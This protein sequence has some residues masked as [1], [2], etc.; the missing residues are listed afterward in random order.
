MTA[1]GGCE[2]KSKGLEDDIRAVQMKELEILK[3]VAKVCEDNGLRYFANGGTLLGAVRHKGFIPWDDDV[4]IGMP[5]KDYERFRQ[6]A[7]QA[8]PEHLRVMDYDREQQV[9]RLYLKVHDI[10]TTDIEIECL[11]RPGQHSGVF[12]DIF[13]YD[14]CSASPEEQ[15]K[16]KKRLKRLEYINIQLRIGEPIAPLRWAKRIILW[17]ARLAL[18]W[19]WASRQTEKLVSKQDMDASEYTHTNMA[20]L[21]PSQWLRQTVR[22]PFEDMQLPCPKEYDKYLTTLYGDYM[23]PPP[24]D[25][26][27][28]EHHVAYRSVDKSYLDRWW[29]KEGL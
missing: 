5:R 13:P 11:P 8:L 1:C 4:D 3:A 20:D 27:D 28:S 2:R 9:T 26:R 25:K 12:I 16:L 29:E 14:G 10:R 18:P 21:M 17:A 7:P 6:I 22:L 23:T 19:N 15:Q 24:E